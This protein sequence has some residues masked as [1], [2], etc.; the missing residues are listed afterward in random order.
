M[1][2]TNDLNCRVTVWTPEQVTDEYG[3]TTY[4]PTPLCQVWA[5]ILTHGG[6]ARATGGVVSQLPGDMHEPMMRHSIII[7]ANALPHIAAGM[8]VTYKGMR[9]NVDFW[10]PHYKH[11][12]RVELVCTMVPDTHGDVSKLDT[13]C[14]QMQGG[15]CYE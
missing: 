6:T 9:Y 7:R 11:N 8:Y 2:L 3:D 15:I 4:R 13:S 5:Q 14:T 1:S 10:R 12:D